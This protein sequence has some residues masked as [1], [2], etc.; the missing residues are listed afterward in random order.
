MN[1]DPAGARRHL[2]A[3]FQIA[4]DMKGQGGTFGYPLITRIGEQLCRFI[5]KVHD[6]GQHEVEVISLH[7][8]AMVLVLHQRIKGDG[9]AVG[10]SLV[11]GLDQMLAKFA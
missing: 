9:G 8:E 1:S 3:I 10:S 5:E 4:H 11:G 2:E 7:V 6:L